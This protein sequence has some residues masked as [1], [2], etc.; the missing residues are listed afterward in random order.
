[1]AGR[2]V[3]HDGPLVVELGPWAT[4]GGH[5]EDHA[6]KRPDVHTTVTSFRRSGDNWVHVSERVLVYQ[7]MGIN[8]Q[9]TYT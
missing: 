3:P 5:L 8:L 2:N 4:A 1:M 6:T 7:G 9:A